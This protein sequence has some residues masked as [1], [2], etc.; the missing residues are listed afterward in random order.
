MSISTFRYSVLQVIINS[1]SMVLCGMDYSTLGIYFPQQAYSKGMTSKDVGIVVGMHSVGS[2]LFTPIWGKLL[3]IGYKKS[4]FISSAISFIGTTGLA[5]VLYV[6]SWPL[7]YASCII[8]RLLEGIGNCGLQVVCLSHIIKVYPTRK[9]TFLGI[10]EMFIVFGCMIGGALSG[11]LFT[12]GGSAAPYLFLSGISLL[13]TV[14]ACFVYE[15][16]EDQNATENEE[17]G[18]YAP[19]KDV[20]TVLVYILMLMWPF[21][22]ALNVALL[23]TTFSPFI[24]ET[25][26]VSVAVSGTVM[27]AGSLGYVVTSV[28]IGYFVDKSIKPEY[29]MILGGIISNASFLFIGPLPCIGYHP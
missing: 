9:T 29:L 21:I 4:F 5:F 16:P 2:T 19:N 25:F 27:S 7:F 13:V 14:A 1:L 26:D 8:T 17:T 11:G 28:T 20:I 3:S 6:E 24:T 22:V 18:Q 10:S 12:L 15:E 23:D